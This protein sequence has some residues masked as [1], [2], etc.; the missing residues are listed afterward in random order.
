MAVNLSD[1]PQQLSGLSACPFSRTSNFNIKAHR[2]VPL[3]VSSMNRVWESQHGG[4]RQSVSG[5]SPSQELEFSQTTTSVAL[6]S[7]L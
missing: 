1:R 3:A 6:L 2:C 4:R 5:V 7:S